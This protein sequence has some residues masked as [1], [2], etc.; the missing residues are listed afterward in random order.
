MKIVADAN[1]PAVEQYFA[2]FGQVTRVQGR[3]LQAAQLR[4][5]DVLLVRSVTRVDAALLAGSGVRF[6]GTAT[7]GLDHIDREYL[8]TAGIGFAS[9]PGA[10][11]NSV[12]EY[13]LA[14][15][16]AVDGQLERLLTGGTVGI[17]GYGAVGRTLARRLHALGVGY[18]I[19]D[20]WLDPR[21]V[22]HAVPLEAVLSADVIT[23]HCELTRR[24]PYPSYR[25]LGDTELGGLG[26]GQLLINASR[27]EVID[28]AAL[29]ARLSGE[30]PPVVVLDVWDGEPAIDMRLLDRLRL[31][32]A[33]IAGY[34]LDGKLAAT[35]ML[36]DAL[37]SYLDTPSAAH[38]PDPDSALSLQ[39][40]EDLSGADLVRHLV[41]R[42]YDIARDDR[43]LRDTA[44]V[45][46][47]AAAFDGLRREYRERRELAGSRVR[48]AAGTPEQAATIA[49]LGCVP[50]F[51]VAQ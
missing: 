30:Q 50:E 13:V 20:P 19:S 38:S 26:A 46:D 49:A 42:V 10:N 39:A 18:R 29:L 11:A 2:P 15:I 43:Q 41:S 9:A 7:S 3:S 35:R 5:A 4:A 36:R 45:N 16:A 47:P 33:H 8:A 24:S 32:T 48:I 1:I 40:P 37:Q 34:S 17:V 14:A 44:R 28:E 51:G 21:S 12:V 27:G 23:L 25:L 22:P 31:G 6:V